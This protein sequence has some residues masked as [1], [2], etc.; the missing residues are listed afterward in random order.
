MTTRM[1]LWLLPLWISLL[2]TASA[3]D[4]SKTCYR[5]DGSFG[6]DGSKWRPCDPGAKSSPCCGEKDFCMDNGLCLNADGNQLLTVQGCTTSSW[7]ECI[8][9]CKD[10]RDSNGYA[11]VWM[12]DMGA[13]GDNVKYCCG[14]YGCCNQS[15]SIKSIS[16]AKVVFRPPQAAAA[17]SASSSSTSTSASALNNNPNQS[18]HENSSSSNNTQALAIGLGVGI[19][20]GLALLGGIVFLGLQVRKWTAAKE[21]QR[22]TVGGGSGG[23]DHAQDMKQYE[24]PH[25][26]LQ[27]QELHADLRGAELG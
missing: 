22:A 12:C 26:V 2:A 14:D 4:D 23:V 19:P 6:S 9:I 16:I 1:I 21:A 3:A 24:E 18:A 5:R 13:E 27:R 7:D 20:M 17:A 11:K 10:Q 8:D 25:S 15:T